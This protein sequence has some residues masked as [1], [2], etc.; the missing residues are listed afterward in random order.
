MSAFKDIVAD[1]VQRT[2][3]WLMLSDVCK[4]CE[5]APCQHACPTGA[6]VYNQF[7]DVYVQNDIC[8]GCGYC[9]V[10]CPFG[11]LGLSDTVHGRE[12]DGRSHKFTL[13]M[14]RQVDGLTPSRPQAR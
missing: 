4:H 9:L 2:G 1:V 5:S 3:R 13:C 8:N 14:D 7:G 11:V 6:I 10:A 12:G